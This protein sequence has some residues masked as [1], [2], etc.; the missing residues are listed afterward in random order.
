MFGKVGQV[1]LHVNAKT[2]PEGSHAFALAMIM[3]LTFYHCSRLLPILGLFVLHTYR[4]SPDEVAVKLPALVQD[5]VYF[6]ERTIAICIWS[7]MRVIIVWCNV[8]HLRLIVIEA[9]YS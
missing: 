3:H 7:D 2:L 8:R 6:T 1:E 9:G 4:D 5:K